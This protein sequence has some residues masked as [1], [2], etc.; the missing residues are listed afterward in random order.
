[1]HDNSDKTI[2]DFVKDADIKLCHWKLTMMY[3]LNKTAMI[4]F[5]HDLQPPHTANS[6]IVLHLDVNFDLEIIEELHE[7]LSLASLPLCDLY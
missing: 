5:V 7:T 2:E 3:L 1:M 4:C 6:W